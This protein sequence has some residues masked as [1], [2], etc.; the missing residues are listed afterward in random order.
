M[1]VD[2]VT[3][4]LKA[5]DGGNGCMSFRRVAH[6][7]KGGPDGG[8]GGKGGDIILVCDPNTAD[9]TDYKFKPHAAAKNGVP[10]KGSDKD[11]ANGDSLKLKMPPGTVVIDEETGNTV[12]EL[13]EY[14]KEY[15]LLKGGKGGKGNTTFKSSTN[16]APRKYT[17]GQ[18]G[19]QGTYKLVLKSIA[20][21]GLVGFPNAGK[22]TLIGL[23]TGAEPKTA[24]YPFTTLQPTVAVIEYP[25]TY[26]RLTM[27][28]IPGLIEGAHENRGLGHRFLRHIERCNLLL[29]LVD[30]AGTDGRDP[31]DDYRQLV[32]ELRYYDE[33]MLDK[34]QLIVANK[35]DEPESPENL[36]R[37]KKKIRRKVHQ[38]S[39]LSE[40]GLPE[41]KAI[42]RERVLLGK[43]R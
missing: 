15:L 32:R 13:I 40:E 27:A 28:D 6:N 23:L 12:L 1:F 34:P 8:N 30:M 31:V 41:L 4:R 25:Q 18:E 26:E 17:P 2:E 19:E 20:D 22:S 35:M 3:I 42:L 7:P 24:S 11:G 5:G 10:G 36:A 29:F 43:T 16:Q 37:F 33:A 9:F 21:I 38:L 14:G 39:C